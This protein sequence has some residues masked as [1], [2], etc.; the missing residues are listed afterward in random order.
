MA[1]PKF[2][3]ENIETPCVKVCALDA[4]RTYCVGCFRTRNEIAR[5]RDASADERRRIKAAATKRA[6]QAGNKME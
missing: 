5:W 1:D 2:A 4:T 3:P 6:L